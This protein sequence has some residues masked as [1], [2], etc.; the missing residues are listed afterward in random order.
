MDLFEK[1][2][3][4][5]PLNQETL[6]KD[7]KKS[8]AVAKLNKAISILPKS[9][10]LSVRNNLGGG[11]GMHRYSVYDHNALRVAPIFEAA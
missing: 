9:E 10:R 4:D 2:E 5:E 11:G 8:S 6:L 3:T 7:L 1:Y